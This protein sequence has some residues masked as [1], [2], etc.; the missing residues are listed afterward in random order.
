MEIVE[1]FWVSPQQRS[2]GCLL[3]DSQLGS[4]ERLARLGEARS[5]LVE[6]ALGLSEDPLER[7][8]RRL[9]KAIAGSRAEGPTV[10][11][12][13]DEGLSKEAELTIGEG[14]T[15]Q[16]VPPMDDQVKELRVGEAEIGDLDI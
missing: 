12:G 15:A 14:Q 10:L 1:E 9:A 2:L 5:G 16:A 3:F 7:S 6:A 13:A 8:A 11:W 4:H